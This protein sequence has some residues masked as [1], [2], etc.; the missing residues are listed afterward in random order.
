MPRTN[1]YCDQCEK[2]IGDDKLAYFSDAEKELD[3]CSE[4]CY[5]KWNIENDWK[6]WQETIHSSFTSELHEDWRDNDF[7]Y[8]ECK[9]W[10][11]IGLKSNDA[12]FAYWLKNIKGYTTYWISNFGDEE[13]LRER[14]EKHVSNRQKVSERMN[15][16][17]GIK[18]FI[19][20]LRQMENFD[21]LS[22]EEETGDEWKELLKKMFS[23]QNSREGYEDYGLCEEC[24]QPYTS[25]YAGYGN[26]ETVMSRK[27]WCRPCNAQH[28][29]DNFSN[30]T[31][32]NSEIDKFIQNYQ[33]KID[34]HQRVLEWIPY[35]QFTD[36][37]YLAEGGFGK[38]YRAK[39]NEGTI[40]EWSSKDNK[41]KRDGNR[42]IILKILHDS[43]NLNAD[44]L[45]EIKCHM[46]FDFS[47]LIVKCFGISCDPKTG[48][49]VMIMGY[50]PNGNL[51]EYL[52]S[53]SNKMYLKN[54]FWHLCGI[55][56]QLNTIHQ[57]NLIHRDFHPGNILGDITSKHAYWWITDLGLCRPANRK[58]KE[59]VYGVLPYVA[60]EV[61][62]GQPYTQA[63]DIYSFGIVTYEILTN[64]YPYPVLDNMFT[65]AVCNGLRPNLDSVKAPEVLKDLISKC[66]D[67][68]PLRR[69]TANEVW[70]SLWDWC[71][72][73]DD[74]KKDDKFYQQYKEIEAEYNKFSQSSPYKLHPTAVTYSKPINTKKISE[75]LNEFSKSV[76]FKSKELNQISWEEIE[77]TANWQT[78]HPTFTPQLISSWQERGF[79]PHQTQDWLNIGLTPQDYNFCAWLRNEIKITPTELLNDSSRLEDLR[80]QFNEHQQLQPYI[81]LPSK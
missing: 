45:Q 48:N 29:K 34:N 44:F 54:K 60:P 42:E 78:L 67:A 24:N 15:S 2:D 64:S 74:E 46:L 19:E 79:T 38:V 26:Q 4:E 9:R 50:I 20:E 76:E 51:R 75:E 52:K 49:Y 57:R 69:P 10:I 12:D 37:E 17:E 16:F 5:S 7:N 56:N 80:E 40:Y 47:D 31:S 77:E 23:N 6:L 30:W 65:L 21:D 13:V 61:L 63:S 59:N 62:R 25:P 27:G 58:D 70:Q 14:H 73:I 32:D 39:W 18:N 8:Q 68:D 71:W 43:Q 81:E 36:I 35:E 33:L 72:I 11:K 55:A 3:F 1:V 22:F 53:S 66:W 28:F 41:W